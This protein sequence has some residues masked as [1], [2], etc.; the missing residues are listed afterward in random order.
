MR[1]TVLKK[2]WSAYLYVLLAIVLW[3]ST[4]AVSKLILADITSLQLIFFS[5]PF[6]LLG[7][8]AILFFQGK[9]RELFRYRGMDFLKLAGMGFLGCFLYYVFLFGAIE[10]TS[11]QEAF[12]VNYL[13]PIMVVLFAVPILKEKFSWKTVLAISLSFLGVV[14]VVS[15]G[16]GLQIQDFNGT[17]IGM[18]AAGA[19]V[20][21]LFSVL[22]KKLHYEVYSSMFYYT[23]FGFL[24][25]SAALVSTP[26]PVISWSSLL[27]LAWIGI[28]AN[29]LAYVF[30]FKALEIGNTAKMSNLIFLTPFVSLCFITILT[31]EPILSSSVLGLLVIVSGIFVGR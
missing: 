24:F 28:F 27:G 2:S 14:I 6:S 30:W 1:L 7:I 13:W 3:G 8:L 19:V 22:G 20:Y 18:A 26:F 29:G 12:I 25:I 9:A 21:G 5:A 4:P 17:A 15:K 16:Q 31:G 10:R 23:L 11:A